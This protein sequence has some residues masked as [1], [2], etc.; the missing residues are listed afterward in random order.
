M[1]NVNIDQY[2]IMTFDQASTSCTFL[3]PIFGSQTLSFTT[4]NFSKILFICS[5]Y[6]NLL[7]LNIGI[8]LLILSVDGIKYPQIVF[9]PTRS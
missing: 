9:L 1:T 8:I 6:N 7:D 3:Q 5:L 2:I 4:S